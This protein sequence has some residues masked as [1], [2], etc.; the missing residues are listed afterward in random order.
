M[1]GVVVALLNLVGLV[2]LASAIMWECQRDTRPIGQR[3]HRADGALFSDFE[4]ARRAMND[5]AGQSWRNLVE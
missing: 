4:S 5:L 3:L 2:L 1:I